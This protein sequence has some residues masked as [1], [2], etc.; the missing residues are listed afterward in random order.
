MDEQV[1]P[2]DDLFG[3]VNGRWLAETEI[4]SDRSSWGPFV[5]LADVAEEQVRQIIEDLAAG[6][7]QSMSE[8]ARKIG[9]LYASFMDTD[10]IERKGL[11]PVRPLLDAVA[12]LRGVRALAAVLGEFERIGGHG[13]F[14]SYVSTDDRNSDRFLFHLGQGGLGL[15]DESYYREEKFAEVREKYVA[16]LTTLLTRAEIPDAE[17]AART[18]LA[19]D[20]KLAAGHWERAETRDVQKTYNLRTAEQLKELCP[21]F[22]WDAY[23]T[24]LGGSDE[25]IAEVCV[26]QPSFFSHLA[27]VLDEVPVE[28]WRCWMHT[29]VLRSAAA[30]LTED[31]VETNFDFYGRT[32]NGTPELRVRWK[33]GVALVEGAI[34]EAVG[35]EYVARHFPPRSKALMDELVGNLL[36]AYRQSISRLDWMT[37]ETKDRAFQKLDRF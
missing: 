16:Y 28:D 17:A 27:R 22:D 24:N 14:G 8:D 4:P 33:R 19:I 31:L 11:R 32:L 37:D 34:G 13:L 6:D 25:T 30:Y 35:R 10:H 26:R 7:R 3:Y 2:Q 15:P 23:V 12:G 36:A 18:V 29:R 9:D 5:Q 20:T 21:S 1:R